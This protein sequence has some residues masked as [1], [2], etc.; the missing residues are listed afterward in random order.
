MRSPIIT[1]VFTHTDAPDFFRDDF[2]QEQQGRTKGRFD[3]F[4]NGFHKAVYNKEN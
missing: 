3:Y 2:F 4:K 1:N